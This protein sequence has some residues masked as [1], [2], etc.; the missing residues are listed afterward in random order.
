MPDIFQ[1]FLLSHDGA[2][3]YRNY[4]LS[5]GILFRP[6]R[7]PR[8]GDRPSMSPV[9]TQSNTDTEETHA[10][11]HTPTEIDYQCSSDLSQHTL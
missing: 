4:F 7:T 3:R 6:D 2:V 11:I 10:D 5:F 9:L 8:T 1:V